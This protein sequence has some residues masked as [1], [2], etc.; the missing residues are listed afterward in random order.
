[1][2]TF[3]RKDLLAVQH[4]WYGVEHPGQQILHP[5]CFPSPRKKSKRPKSKG[6]QKWKWSLTWT[7]GR[8][9]TNFCEVSRHLQEKRNSSFLL[10]VWCPLKAFFFCL[11]FFYYNKYSHTIQHPS[12]Q[13]RSCSNRRRK[14]NLSHRHAKDES[15]SGPMEKKT[16]REHCVCARVCVCVCLYVCMRERVE[17]CCGEKTS[18]HFFRGW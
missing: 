1:M 13:A 18:I 6:E 9:L 12:A 5:S 14:N 2:V 16:T 15:E 8:V 4:L 17:V 11:L 10:D 3:L 7:E